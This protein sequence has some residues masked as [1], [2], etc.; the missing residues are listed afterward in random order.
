M[1]YLLPLFAVLLLG[2]CASADAGNKVIT[3]RYAYDDPQWQQ[4][5]RVYQATQQQA[6]DNGVSVRDIVEEGVVDGSFLR[7]STKLELRLSTLSIVRLQQN[8]T[9][10]YNEP[11]SKAKLVPTRLHPVL[12]KIAKCESNNEL[13]ATAEE[14]LLRGKYLLTVSAWNSVGGTGD[15]RQASEEEQDRRAAALLLRDGP[16][17]WVICGKVARP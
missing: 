2:G 3:G 9:F 16:G 4:A 1:K 5:A 10:I 11:G 14:G 12:G 6:A 13:R 15:P 7:R 17:I 8:T